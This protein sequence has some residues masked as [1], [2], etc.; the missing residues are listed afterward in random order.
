[1]TNI[2]SSSP[3][4]KSQLLFYGLLGAPIAMLGIP[5][6][7]YLPIYYHETFGLSLATIGLALLAARLF[8]VFTDPLMGWISDQINPK[9][10]RVW[11]VLSGSGL[12]I[13]AIYQLFFPD[14]NNVNGWTLFF[15]SFV[16]YLAW[17]WIQVPYLSLAAEIT[18]HDYGKSQLTASRESLAILGVLSVLILPFALTLEIHDPAFYNLLFWSLAVLFALFSVSLFK[19]K[20]LPQATSLSTLANSNNAFSPIKLLKKLWHQESQVFKIMPLYFLNNFANAL[21]A[22]LFILF[23]SDF[24]QLEADKGLFLIAYFIAGIIALPFWLW[25]SKKWGKASSWKASMLLASVSFCGVFLLEPGDFN[26]FLIISL[27]TGLSLGVDL[28]M[29]ASMQAD[30]I[31]STRQKQNQISGLLFG[32]WGMLTKLALALAVGIAF[33]LLEFSQNAPADSLMPSETFTLLWLYAGIP[34]VL[35]LIAVYK[36]NQWQSQH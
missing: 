5:L 2:Q 14:S 30:M 27:M 1:M 17:T 9:F 11:Q 16:T 19:L 32:I 10:N 22:T 35:K 28:A 21:P 29:P 36:L 7:L 6:Y 15:W 25:L 23:V 3:V 18:T 34:I 31:Q 4:A 33:P 12:L 24:L 8:D 20:Q 13:F 26:G